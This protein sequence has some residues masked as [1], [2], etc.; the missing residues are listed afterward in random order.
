MLSS[1]F[2]LYTVKVIYSDHIF[3]TDKEVRDNFGK[4]MNVQ[5]LVGQPE[6]FIVGQ[7]KNNIEEKLTYVESRLEGVEK[8]LEDR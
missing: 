1:G 4:I 2:L 7:C 3:F 6:I 8:I 5:S